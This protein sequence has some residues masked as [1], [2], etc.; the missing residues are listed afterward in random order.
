[1]LRPL[2]QRPVTPD[3]GLSDAGEKYVQ[4]LRRMGR[5]LQDL[6]TYSMTEMRVDTTITFECGM[7]TY[8]GALCTCDALEWE[9]LAALE[10]GHV[11]MEARSAL[12]MLKF[13]GRVHARSEEPITRPHGRDAAIAISTVI[14]FRGSRQYEVVVQ[15]RSD[16]AAAAHGGLWHVA[17]SCMFQP[18]AGDALNE[19]S[20]VHNVYREYLEELFRVPET[21]EAPAVLSYDYFYDNSNLKFLRHL[22]EL[23]DAALLCTGVSVNLLNLRPEICML[24]HID[25]PEWFRKHHS[26]GDGLS[27]AELNGEFTRG[28]STKPVSW[29]RRGSPPPAESVPPCSGALWLALR[30]SKTLGLSI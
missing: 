13:R 12:E 27:R 4:F 19:Y 1:M 3:K 16:A 15:R 2:V 24:L 7:G 30:A 18:V 5:P 21:V 22:L 14:I 17:P 29:I 26:G 11:P 25:T 9:I 8:F 20:I 28:I 23:G 10:Q 6:P